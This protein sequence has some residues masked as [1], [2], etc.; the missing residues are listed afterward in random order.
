MEYILTDG[1]NSDFITLC[2]LLDAYLDRAAG[3]RE[4]RAQR[5]SLNTLLTDVHDVFIAYGG[6]RP[7]GAPASKPIAGRLWRSNGSLCGRT[8]GAGA[9]PKASCS[10]LRGWRLREVMPALSWRRQGSCPGL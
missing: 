4:N 10:P 9:S 2:S 6:G 1:A 7:W 3:G 8:A 5:V